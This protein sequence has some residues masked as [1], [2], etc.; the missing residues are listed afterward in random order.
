MGL[1]EKTY[2]S[3]EAACP[4][5]PL[6]SHYIILHILPSWGVIRASRKASPSVGNFSCPHFVQILPE[7]P[8]AP[9]KPGLTG[10][11]PGFE[12]YQESPKGTWVN[13]YGT[14]SQ[15]TWIQSL[16]LPHTHYVSLGKTFKLPTWETV[17][18]IFYLARLL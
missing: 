12:G 18:M 11:V 7:T 3:L 14:G 10:R 13:R 9:E 1:Y 16:A 5:S 2:V 15:G 17:L 4:H 6:V 8:L